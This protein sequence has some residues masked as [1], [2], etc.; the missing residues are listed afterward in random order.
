MQANLR[1]HRIYVDCGIELVYMDPCACVKKRKKDENENESELLNTRVHCRVNFEFMPLLSRSISH[2]RF[3][4]PW[5]RLMY[6]CPIAYISP[7][8]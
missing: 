6:R 5:F 4:S 8:E 3:S 1:T 7:S 2:P